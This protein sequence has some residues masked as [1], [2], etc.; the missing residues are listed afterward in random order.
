MGRPE[1]E[2]RF[3]EAD[4]RL[5]NASR[6]IND[7]CRVYPREVPWEECVPESWVENYRR[8]EQDRDAAL[9]FM[10]ELGKNE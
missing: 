5:R 10:E 9:L 6:Q 4:Q 8:L 7:E 3:W 2:A 1:A